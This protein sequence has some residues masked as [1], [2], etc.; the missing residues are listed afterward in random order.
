V[1]Q[2]GNPIF[3][4]SSMDLDPGASDFI[5]LSEHNRWM[6]EVA[7]S[8]IRGTVLDYGCGGQPY[9]S[10]IESLGAH[11]VG[12]DVE[13]AAGV[14]PDLIIEPGESLP[15]ADA[16]FDTVV[17]TQVLEHVADPD[18]YLSEC[19]RL[20]KP[21]GRLVISVPMQWRHHEVPHDYRRYT[22]FGLEH[23]LARHGFT[24]A[25]L[26]PCGGAFALSGQVVVN[27][28]VARGFHRRPLLSLLNRLALWL[29]RR[30]PD[31]NDTIAWL[32]IASPGPLPDG[33]RPGS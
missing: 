11:Y 30:Y 22:R 15:L 31:P 27:T 4:M 2:A 24:P 10:L 14:A 7:G 1:A 17:S 8:V 13:A 28:L 20:L 32:C 25:D 18:Q 21:D 19:R 33:G 16:S 26:R 6:R 3:R 29:D 5:V 23:A 9:R 12:A